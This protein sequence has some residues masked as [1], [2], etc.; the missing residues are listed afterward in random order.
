MIKKLSGSR[1]SRNSKK[2]QKSNKSNKSKKQNKQNKMQEGGIRTVESCLN[3]IQKFSVSNDYTACMTGGG[4]R[5]NFIKGGPK[6]EKN[7]DTPVKEI[8]GGSIDPNKWRYTLNQDTANSYKVLI[9]FAK[10]PSLDLHE[11][12]HDLPFRFETFSDASNYA[13]NAFPGIKYKITGSSDPPHWTNN[14][15]NYFSDI[16]NKI[17]E[18]NYTKTVGGTDKDIENRNARETLRNMKKLDL[19]SDGTIMS[20]GGSYDIEKDSNELMK[21]ISNSLNKSISSYFGGSRTIS[22]L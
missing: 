2:S 21:H 8:T 19:K 12:F 1:K 5:L 18:N 22:K 16:K 9:A 4:N 17:M 3:D 11:S 6:L 10:V 15:P 7:I 20:G 13:A 14:D